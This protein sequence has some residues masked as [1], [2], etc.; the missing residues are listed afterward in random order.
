VFFD[1]VCFEV[2]SRVEYDKLLSEAMRVNA[3][4]VSTVKMVFLWKEGHRIR[5]LELAFSYEETH[6]TAVI[7]ETASQGIS[8]AFR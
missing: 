2:K 7:Q 8:G 1:H 3:W 5:T 6:Q 4:V